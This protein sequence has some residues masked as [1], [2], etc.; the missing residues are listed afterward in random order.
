MSYFSLA[1]C[2]LTAGC[3]YSLIQKWDYW[4]PDETRMPTVEVLCLTLTCPRSDLV[5][6]IKKIKNYLLCPQNIITVSRGLSF[7]QSSYQCSQFWI[8]QRKGLFTPQLC[9][10]YVCWRTAEQ[11]RPLLPQFI[12]CSLS[13][14]SR[15]ERTKEGKHQTEIL[16]ILHWPAFHSLIDF[17]SEPGQTLE[18]KGKKTFQPYYCL[19]LCFSWYGNTKSSFSWLDAF[20][21]STWNLASISIICSNLLLGEESKRWC[22]FP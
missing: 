9:F 1:Q 22:F 21:G 5:H 13:E 12:K 17:T 14:S 6:L 7:L 2:A 4:K 16:N 8:G 3:V 15:M 18:K 11:S 19:T 20:K 10:L